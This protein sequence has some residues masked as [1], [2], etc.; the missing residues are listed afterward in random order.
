MNSTHPGLEVCKG[1]SSVLDCSS[2]SRC[3]HP[4]FVAYLLNATCQALPADSSQPSC[5]VTSPTTHKTF[6]EMRKQAEWSADPSW[7]SMEPPLPLFRCLHGGGCCDSSEGHL[8]G[9]QLPFLGLLLQPIARRT[10]G[11]RG[12]CQSPCTPRGS[13]STLERQWNSKHRNT[14]CCI[15]KYRKPVLSADLLHMVLTTCCQK[16]KF[17]KQK[18]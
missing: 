14:E 16:K 9:S 13:P 8:P 5:G 7:H 4:S 17:Q 10:S 2:S 12:S 1:P 3:P 18:F 11:L 15:Q 6:F